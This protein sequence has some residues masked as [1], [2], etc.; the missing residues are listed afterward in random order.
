[1]IRDAQLNTL[2]FNM[3]PPK[4]LGEEPELFHLERENQEKLCENSLESTPRRV[5]QEIVSIAEDGPR[6]PLLGT[7]GGKTVCRRGPSAPPPTRR[8]ERL[9]KMR[10][11]DSTRP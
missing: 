3:L 4:T 5:L 1:M 11:M 10:Q 9:A 8:S 6:F 2:T 7:V